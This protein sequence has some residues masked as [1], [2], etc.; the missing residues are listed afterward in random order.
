MTDKCII[1]HGVLGSP[2]ICIYYFNRTIFDEID[3]L[4]ANLNCTLMNSS[5]IFNFDVIFYRITFFNGVVYGK[6]Y[7]RTLRTMLKYVRV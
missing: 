1:R 5:M 7:S 3:K 6:V 2:C 4:C